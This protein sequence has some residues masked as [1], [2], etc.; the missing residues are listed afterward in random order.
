MKNGVTVK[1][2]KD[3]N[4]QALTDLKAR[5]DADKR[6][7]KIGYPAGDTEPDGTSLALI[8]RVHEYGSPEQGIPERPFL[9]SGITQN[10]DKLTAVSKGLLVN[11][12]Q[13]SRDV[14]N[15]LGVLGEVARTSVQ[16]KITEGPFTPNNAA[17]IKRKG[18]SRPLIDTGHLRSGIKAVSE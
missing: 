14:T 7:I 10:R 1:I 9:Q 18:S 16:Q 5:L 11:I 4:L 15:A 13:G 6:G 3:I 8:A 2:V 12:I 17:T